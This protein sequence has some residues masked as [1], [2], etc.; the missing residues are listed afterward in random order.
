MDLKPDASVSWA[1]YDDGKRDFAYHLTVNNEAN[2]HGKDCLEINVEEYDPDLNLEQN[3]VFFV[4]LEAD[5]VYWLGRI[6]YKNGIKHIETF[7]DRS[8]LE[9]WGIGGEFK[10]STIHFE[11]A[12]DYL[13]E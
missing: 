4:S 8:F 5:G 11:K 10:P 7:K 1:I 6:H 12:E 9:N 13:L 3:F 2:V